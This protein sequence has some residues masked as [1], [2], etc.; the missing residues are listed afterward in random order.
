[1]DLTVARKMIQKYVTGHSEFLKR[2]LTADR[3][4]DNLNDILFAPS[5]QEKEAKGDIEN[6][7]R[8]ADNRIPMSFYSLLVDQKVSYLLLPH[9]CLIHIAMTSIR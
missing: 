5:R 6:P 4:Y 1:M 2:A 3:Y 9:L 8:T 7:M